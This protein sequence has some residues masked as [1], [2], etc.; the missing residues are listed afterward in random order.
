M[1]IDLLHSKS[2]TRTSPGLMRRSREFILP[3]RVR[4]YRVLILALAV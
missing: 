2:Q 4:L 1:A 3:D